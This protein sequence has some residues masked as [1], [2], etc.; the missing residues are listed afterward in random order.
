M[1]VIVNG[2][3]YGK[4][5]LNNIKSYV[6]DVLGLDCNNNKCYVKEPSKIIALGHIVHKDG[7]ITLLGRNVRKFYKIFK[8]KHVADK[9]LHGVL[10]RQYKPEKKTNIRPATIEDIVARLNSWYGHFKLAK[11]HGII[12]KGIRLY[13]N[14][15]IQFD[16]ELNKFTLISYP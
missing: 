1:F 4:F 13:G 6:N 12:E 3:T 8:I 10:K 2:K 11:V 5:I 15:L 9:S 14:N 16:K 7:N